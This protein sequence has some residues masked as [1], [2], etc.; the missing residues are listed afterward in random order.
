VGGGYRLGS[1]PAAT[2][3]GVNSDGEERC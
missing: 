3:S 1:L 2:W